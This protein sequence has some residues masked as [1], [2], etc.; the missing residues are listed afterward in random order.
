[1]TVHFHAFGFHLRGYVGHGAALPAK[2]SSS[3]RC[4]AWACGGTGAPRTS[5]QITR[6]GITRLGARSLHIVVVWIL[7]DIAD[8]ENDALG[9]EVLPP[10]RGAE[11][12]GSDIA[13]LVQNGLCAVAGVF[14]DLALLHK[15]ESGPIVVAVPW[16]DAAGLD[17][18]LAEAQL[19]VL[20]VRRLRFE[21]D[22]TERHVGYA[23]RLEFDFL[24]GVRLHLVSRAFAGKGG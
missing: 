15:N 4:D 8:I 14:N 16:H 10:M 17:R 7:A 12:L 22:R 19:A 5:H 20:E 6:L 24:T 11:H 2:A 23:D 13:G 3:K 9:T 18:Q 1:M 21:V